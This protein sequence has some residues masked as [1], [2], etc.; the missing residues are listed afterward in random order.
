MTPPS[1]VQLPVVGRRH[2]PA[3]I[4]DLWADPVAFRT[5]IAACAAIAAV[6]LDP[7]ILDPGMPAMRA[8]IKSDEGI[9]SLL[10]LAAVI[11]AGFLLA[12]GLVADLLRS[13]RLV[14]VALVGLA[15]SAVLAILLSDGWPLVGVRALAWACTGL[16]LPF[17]IGAV[18]MSYRGGARATALGAAYGVYGAAT[19]I[20]PA[21]ALI[22]GATGSPWPAFV[23]CAVVALIAAAINRRLPDLPGAERQHRPTIVAVALFSFGVVA[24]VAALIQVGSGM[25]PI[26]AAVILVGIVCIALAFVPRVRSRDG[27]TTTGVDL[28]PVA[29]ALGV[30]VVVGF[31]QA[32][33]ML[34][35][36]QFFTA[37]QGTDPLL[38]TIAIAPF[39]VALLVAGP[40]S[41]WLL[42][43]FRPRVLMA[44]GAIAIGI[45]NLMLA[46]ILARGT[47]YP[48]FITPFL[49][50]GAGF[51]I[52]T[53]VRTAIIFA[54]VPSDLPASAAALNE[55]SIGMGAR[56]G[57]VV[58]VVVTTSMALDTFKNT[59]AGLA[60]PL[61]D[62][63]M[64]DFR[65]ILG[66]LSLRSTQELT[67]GLDVLTIRSYQEAVVEGMRVA[68]LVPGVVAILTG[69]IAYVLMGPRDP[70]RS[71]WEL[72]D[73]R[74]APD[75]AAGRAGPDEQAV[76]QAG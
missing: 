29:V 1:A 5:L 74:E 28:R 35:L 75:G 44:G 59:L 47:E 50:I 71:V 13:E 64:A 39:V 12:G 9:R 14:R 49:L 10:M 58:A 56:V 23:L 16:V 55:A 61:V 4:T 30:G 27:L 54:S 63:R 42:V 38:A 66:E 68:W 69:I 60:P 11:Q 22:K 6:G 31:A 3:F 72:A 40:V 76:P 51:V 24:L 19:A 15:V 36:P 46:L 33:P 67:A 20:A 26:R 17:A 7:H 41:G 45:A 37:I 8:A 25:D 43:R 57:V 65:R 73:E 70:V 34:Q 62:A 52:A 48:W 32:G 18:A 53:T 21:L 2:L